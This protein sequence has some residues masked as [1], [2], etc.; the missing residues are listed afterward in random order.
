VALQYSVAVRTEK[1]LDMLSPAVLNPSGGGA[2]PALFIRTTPVPANPAATVSGA[3]LAGFTIPAA[4][5]SSIGWTLA[6]GVATLAGTW[7]DLSADGTGTAAWFYI[8]PADGNSI[9]MMGTVGASGS[10]AD[11]IVDNTSFLT[12]QAFSVL[13][14][15]LTEGNA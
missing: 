7:Q 15:T 9:S 4:G 10:G 3:L 12:G 14:F 11:M 6:S 5:T 13:S 1:L 8:G 2:H